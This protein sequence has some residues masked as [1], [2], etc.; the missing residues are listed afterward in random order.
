MSPH[1]A[2][3][4]DLVKSQK[5]TKGAE[6]GVDKGVLFNMLLTGCPELHLVGVDTGVV[7]K[8]VQH[9]RAIVEDFPERALFLEMTTHEAAKH[10]EDGHFD[11]VFIDADHGELAVSDDV[12]Q[13]MPKVRKGGWLGGHDYNNNFPGVV[14]AVQKAFGRRVETWPGSIWGVW[15]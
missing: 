10:F 15:Q 5:W 11:F 13:W 4:V 7:E 12:T 3:L 2:V 14:Q 1:R 8:R 6:L 9:V